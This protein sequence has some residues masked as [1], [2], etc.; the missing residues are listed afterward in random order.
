MLAKDKLLIGRSEWCSLPELSVPAIKAKI[1]TGAKTSSIH[2]FNVKKSQIDN[3]TWVEFEVHPVPG[4][5]NLIIFCK[6]LMID[7]RSIM[8]SNGLKE[9]RP[10]ISTTLQL[11]SREWPIEL[12]L[13]N[14]EPLKHRMLLGREALAKFVIIDPALYLHCGRMTADEVNESY[15]L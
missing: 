9:V 12:T 3:Q 2:A 15:K 13:S 1:D 5:D 14:R 8:S 10:V 7:E 6:K 11:G 4:N